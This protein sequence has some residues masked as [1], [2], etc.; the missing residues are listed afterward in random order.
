M[1]KQKN[2]QLPNQ[3]QVASQLQAQQPPEPTEA[4]EPLEAPE[5]EQGMNAVEKAKAELERRKAESQAR[6]VKKDVI[7]TEPIYRSRTEK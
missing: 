5:P 1:A 4:P 2:E 3:S 6:A 7:S